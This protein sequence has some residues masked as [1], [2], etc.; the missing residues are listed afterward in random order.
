MVIWDPFLLLAADLHL[1]FETFLTVWDLP[2]TSDYVQK[3][4]GGWRRTRFP[5]KGKMPKNV[6]HSTSMGVDPLHHLCQIR[7]IPC[8]ACNSFPL[9]PWLLLEGWQYSV[10]EIGLGGCK[11]KHEKCEHGSLAVELGHPDRLSFLSCVFWEMLF[12]IFCCCCHYNG[13]NVFYT[14][15]ASWKSKIFYYT[16]WITVKLKSMKNPGAYHGDY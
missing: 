14:F 6:H 8:S 3:F 9:L 15:F 16:W 12:I 5:L 1:V 2:K 4:P 13:Y 11:R 7:L 10:E